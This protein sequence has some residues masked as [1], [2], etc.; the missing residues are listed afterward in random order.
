MHE[1]HDVSIKRG[2]AALTFTRSAYYQV[3]RD[4][5]IHDQEVIDALNA[6]VEAHPRWG[7]WKCIARL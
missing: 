5:S 3:L 1:T 6:L 7:V 2:R 4:W